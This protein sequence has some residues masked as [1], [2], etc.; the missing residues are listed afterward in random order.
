M[1]GSERI[2]FTTS[3]ALLELEEARE[4]LEKSTTRKRVEQ[5]ESA[6]A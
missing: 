5:T 4:A 1:K 2:S 3:P 6:S